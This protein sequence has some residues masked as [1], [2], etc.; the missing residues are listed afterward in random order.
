MTIIGMREKTKIVLKCK[1]LLAKVG[2]KIKKSIE[3]ILPKELLPINK[4]QNLLKT[5]QESSSTLIMIKR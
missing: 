5:N 4:Y 1:T 2:K 3:N